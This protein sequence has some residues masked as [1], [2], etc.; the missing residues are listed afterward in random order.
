MELCALLVALRDELAIEIMLLARLDLAALLLLL[1]TLLAVLDKA[2]TLDAAG[3]LARL[4]L[5]K[6]LMALEAS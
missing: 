1:E 6:L 4:D 5:A 3:L 2:R